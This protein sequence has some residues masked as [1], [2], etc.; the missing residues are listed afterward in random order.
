MRFYDALVLSRT[1]L[2]S[3]SDRHISGFQF[4]GDVLRVPLGAIPFAEVQMA[5]AP[6][7]SHCV[8]YYDTGAMFDYH[9]HTSSRVWGEF[10]ADSLD[11]SSRRA[12]EGDRE[13]S[14]S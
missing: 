3:D 10:H 5:P 9:G 8:S 1:R 6:F 13:P 4:F 7:T 2:R 12:M 14:S 11:P